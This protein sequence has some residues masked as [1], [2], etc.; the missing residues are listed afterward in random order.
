M[1]ARRTTPSRERRRADNSNRVDQGL[2]LDSIVGFS[3]KESEFDVD[4]LIDRTRS[5]WRE[6]SFRASRRRV[7]VYSKASVRHRVTRVPGGGGA[8]DRALESGLA[9]RTWNAG[10]QAAGFAASSGL[11]IDSVRWA[12]GAAIGSHAQATTVSPGAS[13]AILEER[14]DLDPEVTLPS[15]AELLEALDSHP[16]THWVEAGTTVEILAG[17]D[18][19]ITARRRH[20]FWALGHGR[21]LMAQRGFNGWQRLLGVD[22]VTPRRL[23]P[24]ETGPAGVVL[25]PDA[26]GVVVASLAERFHGSE[27]A[28]WVTP[29]S[30]WELIDDP[31]APAGLAG[32]SFDDLG[33]PAARRVLCK[34]RLWVGGTTGPGTFWRSSFRD[35]PKESAANLTVLGDTDQPAGHC[36]ARHCNLLR[37]S[38][39][40]WVLELDLNDAK[41]AWLRATPEA[42]L[43]GCSTRLGGAVVTSL[44][45]IVPALRFEGLELV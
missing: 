33:F 20:R 1:R 29:G 45:P 10:Q 2:F 7:E 41:R 16:D 23:H 31:I 6:A 39:N 18:G 32:G 17:A 3:L 22:S 8:I 19:W 5:L 12:V 35:T 44:G 15:D 38:P 4:A 9:V 14:R 11:S 25:R 24:N 13:D 30:G 27:P 43:A 36:V 42:I 34:D 21:S 28:E 40:V 37:P 26:A